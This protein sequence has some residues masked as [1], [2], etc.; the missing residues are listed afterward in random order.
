MWEGKMTREQLY[1]NV[2]VVKENHWCVV[3]DSKA[4]FVIVSDAVY[5]VGGKGLPVCKK[6]AEI[7]KGRN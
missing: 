5:G 1:K 6:C 3:C 7:L 4:D 2:K